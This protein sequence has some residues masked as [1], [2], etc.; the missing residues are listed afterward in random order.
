MAPDSISYSPAVYDF[1]RS[2][3]RE[4]GHR[5]EEILCFLLRAY[6]GEEEGG[7]RDALRSDSITFNAV[8]LGLIR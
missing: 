4:G 3:N 5:A 1:I 7:G 2:E 6:Y 8:L